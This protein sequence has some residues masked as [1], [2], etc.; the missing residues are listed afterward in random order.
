MLYFLGGA[1]L[2][3]L[4]FFLSHLLGRDLHP[5]LCISG[6]FMPSWVGEARRDTMLPS[7]LVWTTFTETKLHQLPSQVLAFLL[8]VPSWEDSCDWEIS[9]CVFGPADVNSRILFVEFTCLLF[10]R[11]TDTWFRIPALLAGGL[12]TAFGRVER[13]RNPTNSKD[14]AKDLS[15][16]NRN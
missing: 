5:C 3:A 12:P 14:H 2:F 10:A 13:F 9:W 8:V 7:I 4:L 15:I 1:G 11:T 6:C 16:I